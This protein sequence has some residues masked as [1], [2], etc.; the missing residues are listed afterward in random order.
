M[1]DLKDDQ[2]W[3]DVEEHYLEMHM[4]GTTLDDDGAWALAKVL[5]ADQYEYDKSFDKAQREGRPFNEVQVEDM[6]RRRL[7]KREIEKN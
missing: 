4:R 2:Y 5:V 7:E 1:D 6:R 3:K